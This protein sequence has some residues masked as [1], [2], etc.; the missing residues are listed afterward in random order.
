MTGERTAAI[1]INAYPAPVLKYTVTDDTP[2]ITTTN[3]AFDDTFQPLPNDPP[4]AAVF[5]HFD[6]VESPGPDDPLNALVHGTA[7][8]VYLDGFGAVDT[9]LARVLPVTDTTGF[10]AFTL[11]DDRLVDAETTGVGDVAS[12]ISHELRN[13]LDVATAHLQAARETGRSEHFET[14]ADAHDRMER[15]IRDVLTLERDPDAIDPTD[16]LA[17]KNAVTDAWQAIDTTDATLNITDTLPTVLA[18]AAQVHRLFE[19]L[20]RNAVEHAGKTVTVRVGPLENVENGIFI[21]DDG[22]G[23]PAAEA[24]AVFTPGYSTENAGTGLGLAIVNRI[25]TAHGWTIRLTTA[26][27]GGAR[28]E[29]RW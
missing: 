26:Q 20:F 21:A 7:T 1:P 18:D 5:D 24:D 11:L 22:N 8:G 23:I 17:L 4:V 19:N 28:F 13:P 2:V 12:M 10:L 6:I 9:Y 27:S 25:V 16:Q 15:I 3:D 29:V 14:V